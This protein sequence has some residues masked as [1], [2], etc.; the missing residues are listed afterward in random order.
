MYG[1]FLPWLNNKLVF[2]P[3]KEGPRVMQKRKQ[4]LER[5]S[6]ILPQGLC[7]IFCLNHTLIL[8][9][10]ILSFWRNVWFHQWKMSNGAKKFFYWIYDFWRNIDLIEYSYTTS[11]L[12]EDV[13]LS[14]SL[15]ALELLLTFPGLEWP[16]TLLFC[17]PS[18]SLTSWLSLI[19]LDLSWYV[20]NW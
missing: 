12:S 1:S 15:E 16:L 2:F 5:S 14:K 8:C 10:I 3:W 7:S 11:S 20:H 17:P 9:L 6:C 18:L 4:I 13:W 19:T